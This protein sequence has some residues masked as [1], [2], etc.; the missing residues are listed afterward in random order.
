MQ[1][2]YKYITLILLLTLGLAAP[3]ARA[4]A[5]PKQQVTELPVLLEAHELIKPLEP[6]QAAELAP[7]TPVAPP[8]PKTQHTASTGLNGYEAG[9]C[10]AWV[11]SK[12]HVPSGWGN[13]SNWKAAAQRAGWT[14][15]TTPVAGAIGWTPGH[16]VYVESVNGNSVTISEQN[17][18]W[19]A[20]ETRTVTKPATAYLYIY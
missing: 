17:Y 6:L 1:I 4:E 2:P 8:A 7:L 13:A 14:V 16:V 5:I 12:R 11:A 15:S 3:P 20:F 19:V 9:Q 18:K 10:T